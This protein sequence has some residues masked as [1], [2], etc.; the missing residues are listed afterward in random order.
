MRTHRIATA[1]LVFPVAL[2]GCKNWPK[3]GGV[4]PS[5]SSLT[6]S[7]GFG[8][9]S[10]TPYQCQGAGTLEL[11]LAGRVVSTLSYTFSGFSGSQAPA[12][13]TAVTFSNLAPATYTLR[14]T[15]GSQS[16]FKTIALGLNSM[17]VRLDGGAFIC[18]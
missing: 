18:S 14:S 7:L 8:A 6:V 15:N 10:N 3:D 5:A 13:Q 17:L 12:C 2:A 4:Q 16:C 1:L 11:S 9:V